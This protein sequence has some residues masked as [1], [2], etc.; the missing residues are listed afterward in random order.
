MGGNLTPRQ[1]FGGALREDDHCQSLK[2][3]DNVREF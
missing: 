2:W 3:P 1:A